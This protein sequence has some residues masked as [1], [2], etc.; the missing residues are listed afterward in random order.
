MWMET[1]LH[2]GHEFESPIQ[3]PPPGPGE[4]KVYANLNQCP[5]PKCGKMTT[6]EKRQWK[7]EARKARSN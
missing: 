4:A 5:N 3:T 6:D 2:C 1:C 7:P